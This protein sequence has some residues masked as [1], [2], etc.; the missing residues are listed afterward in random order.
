MSEPSDWVKLKRGNDWA[1][2]YLNLTTTNNAMLGE[3]KCG[4]GTPVWVR[5]PDGHAAKL[6]VSMTRIDDSYSDHGHEQNTVS[7]VPSVAVESHGVRALVT[8]DQLEVSEA[9]ARAHGAK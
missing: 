7:H 9:W 8:L 3:L 6:R 1:H 5:F 2:H 4:A